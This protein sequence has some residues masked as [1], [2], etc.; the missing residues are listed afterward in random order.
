[1]PVI[2]ATWE[3][4]IR[5]ITVWSQPQANSSG[6]PILKIPN[7]EKDWWSGWSR[8]GPKFKPRYPKKVTLGDLVTQVYE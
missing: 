8:R 1:M 7:T 6:D 4:E 2:L 3:A 5:R